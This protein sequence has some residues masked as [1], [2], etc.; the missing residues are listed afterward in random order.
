MLSYDYFKLAMYKVMNLAGF[1]GGGIGNHEF[2][3]GLPSLSQVTG[4]KFNVDRMPDPSRQKACA[5]APSC[6]CRPTSTA[7]SVVR[8]FSCND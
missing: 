3:Y 1:D 2:N 4:N 8:K 6:R 5:G 7:F